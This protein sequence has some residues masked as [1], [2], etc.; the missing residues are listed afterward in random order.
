[1]GEQGREGE[2]QEDGQSAK[3]RFHARD[4]SRPAP[5]RGGSVSRSAGSFCGRASE[6]A[7]RALALRLCPRTTTASLAETEPMPQGLRRTRT[8]VWSSPCGRPLEKDATAS[9]MAAW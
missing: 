5:S 2:E 4:H 9:R 6:K 7:L 1:F 3:D 8:R